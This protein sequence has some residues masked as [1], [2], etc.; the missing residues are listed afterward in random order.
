[1]VTISLAKKRGS[2]FNPESSHITTANYWA[3]CRPRVWYYIPYLN[4]RF[5]GNS[6]FAITFSPRP[7]IAS[8]P[9]LSFIACFSMDQYQCFTTVRNKG[10]P[11]GQPWVSPCGS[12]NDTT[13]FLPASLTTY[14]SSRSQLIYELISDITV[15]RSLGHLCCGWFILLYTFPIRRQ[16]ILH[17]ILYRPNLPRSNNRCG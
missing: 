14:K 17:W 3:Y 8:S 13:P 9:L 4:P 5:L 15:L 10:V 1:M 7:F 2:G 16:W 11:F 12:P 6:I